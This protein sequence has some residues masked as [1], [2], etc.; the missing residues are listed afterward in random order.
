MDN[1]NLYIENSPV[2]SHQS[3]S[4]SANRQQS[5]SSDRTLTPAHQASSQS[6]ST[7]TVIPNTKS[8]IPNTNHIGLQTKAFNIIIS[9][10]N[11]IIQSILSLIKYIQAYPI[12]I[13]II[14]L[15][16]VTVL[17][18]HSFYLIKLANRIETRLQ[19]LHHLL[20]PSPIRHSL[21]SN[22]KEL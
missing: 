19:S 18:F 20:P 4:A 6:N 21:S 10:L 1:F 22:S 7:S 16:F 8:S 11:L 15:L 14:I 5:Q 13:T 9:F 2:A 3:Q 12:K 17:F